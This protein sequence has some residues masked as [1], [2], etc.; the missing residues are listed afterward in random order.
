LAVG[1]E[2]SDDRRNATERNV[3][4]SI[5]VNLKNMCYAT[6]QCIS[7]CASR[8]FRGAVLL[9]NA[10]ATSQ[11]SM[12]ELTENPL[13][14]EL[15]L[16]ALG[17]QALDQLLTRHLS[18]LDV[19]VSSPL[20]RKSA[21][22][23]PRN[24][25]LVRGA[26]LACVSASA[27]AGHLL[28]LVLRGSTTPLPSSQAQGALALFCQAIS[29]AGAEA[30]DELRATTRTMLRADS[31]HAEQTGLTILLVSLEVR[32]QLL[33]GRTVTEALRAILQSL[34]S[35]PLSSLLP[36]V[37]R[38]SDAGM[39]RNTAYADQGGSSAACMQME[40]VPAGVLPLAAPC[41]NMLLRLRCIDSIAAQ[42]AA[43]RKLGPSGPALLPSL[44]STSADLA[45]LAQC[46]SRELVLH[47]PACLML[48]MLFMQLIASVTSV[49]RQ[50]PELLDDS[51][52]SLAPCC[53]SGLR[54]LASW[55]QGDENA[56]TSRCE[57][58]GHRMPAVV[59][60]TRRPTT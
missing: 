28:P 41:F 34:A 35:R 18:A 7:N 49:V 39:K 37:R 27:R 12:Q 23:S 54:F 52:H 33:D 53:T 26:C 5:A 1:L 58:A 50:R 24:M 59:A 10:R 45:E 21:A 14:S 22:A 47:E 42:A 51:W 40:N 43:F 19:L 32:H 9:C 30:A 46:K 38:R 20:Q 4:K 8:T 6:K 17:S 36:Y 13:S 16:G 60:D 15:Y 56:G 31:M 2:Q 57:A 55:R 3:K 29:A 11:P 48:M 25:S 44:A